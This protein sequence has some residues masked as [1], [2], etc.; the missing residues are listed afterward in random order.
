MLSQQKNSVSVNIFELL[1]YTER[2][3]RKLVLKTKQVD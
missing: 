2:L 3:L 1:T